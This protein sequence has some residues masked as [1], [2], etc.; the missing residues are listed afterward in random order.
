MKAWISAAAAFAMVSAL[1]AVTGS[2]SVAATTIPTTD[3]VLQV[4]TDPG[5]A[6]EFLTF[7]SYPSF[8]DLVDDTNR[9]AVDVGSPRIAGNASSTGLAFDGSRYI[10]QVETDP[11]AATEFLTFVS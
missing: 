11:G 8:Q 3:L 6:T 5:A 2:T 1:M 7:V 10:L 9:I 4:E